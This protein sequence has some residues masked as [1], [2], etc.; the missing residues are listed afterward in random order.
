MLDKYEVLAALRSDQVASEDS[1]RV[2]VVAPSLP[3]VDRNEVIQAA[4][5]EG[6]RVICAKPNEVM[7]ALLSP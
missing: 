2:V 1:H 5:D 3:E 6:V 7:A 4:T